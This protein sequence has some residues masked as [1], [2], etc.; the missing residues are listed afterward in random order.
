MAAIERR[1]AVGLFVAAGAET[2]VKTGGKELGGEGGTAAETVDGPLLRGGE[3]LPEA[4]EDIEGAD[5]MDGEGMAMLLTQADH[6][7]EDLFLQVHEVRAFGR[8]GREYGS[9]ETALAHVDDL[10]ERKEPLEAR[11]MD[12]EIKGGLRCPPRV[13][14]GSVERTLGGMGQTQRAVG[15]LQPAVGMQDSVLRQTDDG[16]AG[17]GVEAVGVKI[18]H[19]ETGYGKEKN[20]TE[21]AEDVL[22]LSVWRL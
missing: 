11:Q 1:Q 9:V 21:T 13:Y 18:E 6:G 19:G 5:A 15:R 10:G 14:A 22:R 2:E 8:I 12:V 3:A 17:N 20:A 16:R 7:D 4:E